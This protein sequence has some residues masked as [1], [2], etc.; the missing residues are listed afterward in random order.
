MKTFSLSLALGAMSLA[1]FAQ[2][3]TAPDFTVTD[4]DGNPVAVGMTMLGE[5]LFVAPLHIQQVAQAAAMEHRQRLLVGFV[6][7]GLQI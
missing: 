2:F 3:G 6:K 5:G 7:D 1:A 4:I